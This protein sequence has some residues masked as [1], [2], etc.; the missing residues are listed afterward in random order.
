MRVWCLMEEKGIARFPRPVF[1]RIP[2]FIGAEKAAERL[3][4]LPEYKAAKAVFC[5][6]DS[7]QRPVREMALRDGKILVMATPRLKR[8]SSYWS[9]ILSLEAVFLG[10]LRYAELSNTVVL[11]SPQ[12]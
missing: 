8:V 5:N 10:R 6:P 11:L 7:P 2:N 12:R 9:Q 3:G 1:H 4:E